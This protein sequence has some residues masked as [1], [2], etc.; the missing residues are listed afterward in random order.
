M[1]INLLFLSLEKEIELDIIGFFKKKLQHTNNHYI[2]FILFIFSI[3]TFYSCSISQ[4]NCAKLYEESKSKKYDIVIVPGIPYENRSLSNLMIARVYWS[5]YLYDQGIT[6]NIM[7]SGDANYTPF[8]EAKIMAL[9]AKIIGISEENI[10]IETDAK[11]STENIY[12]GYYKSKSLGFK[13]IALVTD[14]FQSKM[15]KKFIR[16]KVNKDIDMIP[17]V[18]DT[19]RTLNVNMN[20]KIINDYL[21]YDSNFVHIKKEEPFFRKIN[22]TLGKNINKDIYLSEDD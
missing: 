1:K 13:N 10:F 12:Y 6:E 11:H 22:G 19:L 5:K 15:L 9:Y 8:Y 16:K 20:Q 14:P 7:F 2:K 18:W 3:S 4:K 17:I 21:A